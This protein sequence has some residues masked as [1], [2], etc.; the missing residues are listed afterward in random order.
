MPPSAS[1]LRTDDCCGATAQIRTAFRIIVALVFAG[2]IFCKARADAGPVQVGDPAHPEALPA[3]LANAYES[4]ARD[5]TILPG[6]YNLPA[7]GRNGIELTG[8]KDAAIHA[9]GVTLIFADP[10]HRPLLLNRC[11][12][13]LLEGATLQFSGISFTQGRIQNLGED[14]RGK[15]IDWQID[16]GYP[17]DVDPVKSTY[18]TIDRQTR[19]L[20]PGA[21][22]AGAREA[23]ALG[24]GLFRL[25]GLHGRLG[26][27]AVGDWLVT[28]AKGGDS[29]VQLRDSGHCTMR[30]I[31][32]KHAGFAAFFETNG[33]GGHRYLDCRIALG[34]KPPD[35]A[36][37]P[38]VSCGADGFHSVGTRTG[39]TFER[40]VWEGVLLDDCIAIHGSF[41]KIVRC[42]G[43][44][45][46]LQE[47]NGSGFLAGDSVR[48]SDGK[49]FFAEAVCTAFRVLE[50]TEKLSELTV[51]RNVAVPVEAKAADPNRCG[52]GYR[53][54]HCKLGNTRS[55]GILVKA[56]DGVIDGCTIEGCGMS[57]ISIGP[58]YYWNEAD[59]CK[60]VAVTGNTLRHNG[61]TGAGPAA[62]WVHGDGAVGNRAILIRANDCS[63][64][65]G[66][67]LMSI[68]FAEDV[69]I[70]GN[71]ISLPDSAKGSV[72]R[73]SH[74][75]NVSIKGNTM[76]RLPDAVSLIEIH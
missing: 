39:P 58:E 29:I 62:V 43:A 33:D 8:W 22:D 52:K 32:L 30:D 42:E 73:F 40:C 27:A 35:A 51:D 49:G 45:L 7:T 23:E 13:V 18:N 19:L 15:F 60:H 5:L 72:L 4:G 36:E 56:D 34:P 16:A 21:G 38:L 67:C 76:A 74:S 44:R 69:R 25:R 61:L 12:N 9:P 3:A 2:A 57:A 28:R 70:E 48:I 1:T 75:H 17:R 59:Y 55:R 47:G 71:H 24:P 31:T 65:G 26:G 68:D 50:G 20:K 37:E 64:S 14:A 41:Q 53:I 46:I 6:V 54:L 11:E 63:D 66:D 10:G